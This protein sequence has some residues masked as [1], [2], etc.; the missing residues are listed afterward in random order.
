VTSFVAATTR[1]RNDRQTN[2]RTENR[3]ISSSRKAPALR[4]WLKIPKV[5]VGR[6]L[7][8]VHRVSLCKRGLC[9]PAVSVRPSRSWILVKTNKHI[10]KIF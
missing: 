2:K 10:L 5:R 8:G 9:R 1:P 6:H 4:R 3:W 7:I